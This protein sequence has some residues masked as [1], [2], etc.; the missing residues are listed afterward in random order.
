[1]SPIIL[2]IV[3]LMVLTCMT[4]QRQEVCSTACMLFLLLYNVIRRQLS[5]SSRII[6]IV[7]KWSLIVVEQFHYVN[8]N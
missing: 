8:N 7:T 6:A 5:C 2:A 4:L 3:E 1:M